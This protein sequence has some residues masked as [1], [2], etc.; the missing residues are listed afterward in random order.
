M[1]IFVFDGMFTTGVHDVAVTRKLAQAYPGKQMV[2][3]F[4][5]RR[6]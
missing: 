4:I 6:I 2:G 1:P 3:H 5:A